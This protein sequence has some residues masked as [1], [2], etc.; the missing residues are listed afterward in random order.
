MKYCISSEADS[1]ENRRV[2]ELNLTKTKHRQIENFHFN[3]S[4][5]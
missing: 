4:F 1:E 3:S 2:N 5:D